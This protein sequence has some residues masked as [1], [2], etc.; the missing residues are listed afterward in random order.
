M[1]QAMLQYAGY[2]VLLVALAYPLGKY[3]DNVMR[4]RWVW[5]SPAIRPV[6]RLLYKLTGIDER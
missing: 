6:E 1:M 3:I 2:L 4:G 5:L